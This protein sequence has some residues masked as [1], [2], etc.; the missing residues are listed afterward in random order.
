MFPTQ[1]LH[2]LVA[3]AS[4]VAT[5][6]LRVSC[7]FQIFLYFHFLLQN[8]RTSPPT[9]ISNESDRHFWSTSAATTTADTTADATT[10]DAITI[11]LL[12][13]MPDVVH[14]TLAKEQ[15]RMYPHNA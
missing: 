1:W 2:E 3:T 9:L 15:M 4:K 14:S 12:T 13:P 11:E 10:A 5:F 6:F 8:G 7:F